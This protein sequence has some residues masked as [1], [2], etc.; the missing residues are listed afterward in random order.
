MPKRPH[1]RPRPTVSAF[2]WVGKKNWGD[3]LTEPLLRRFSHVNVQWSLPHEA[4]I[5][6]VGS[7]LGNLVRPEY[8]GVILGSGKLFERGTVPSL[9]RV[10]VLRGP[11]SAE[12][13]CPQG[14]PYEGPFGDPGL[15]AD[16]LISAPSLYKSFDLG[17]VPHWSDKKLALDPRFTRYPH[18][19]INHEDDPLEVI[20]K[21]GACKKIVSSSLH[22]IILA[23]AFC[24]PRRFEA[25]ANWKNEGGLFKVEDHNAAVGIPPQDFKVGNLYK[26]DWHRVCDLKNGLYDAFAE[27]GKNQ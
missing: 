27:F 26:P 16:E 5:V 13:F 2:W 17:I 24:I 14:R 12:G 3:R 9:A 18:I 11:K 22:G 7:I 23:D 10:L 4:G 21:I 25:S 8:R 6:C 19:V 20:R 15:I 1:P